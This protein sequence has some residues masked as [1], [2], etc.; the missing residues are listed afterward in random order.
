[1]KGKRRVRTSVIAH[2]VHRVAFRALTEAHPPPSNLYRI[3]YLPAI[4]VVGRQAALLSSTRLGGET[5]LIVQQNTTIQAQKNLIQVLLGDLDPW[6]APEYEEV[7]PY[8]IIMKSFT[9]KAFTVV[10]VLGTLVTLSAQAVPRHRSELAFVANQSSNNLYVYTIEKNGELLPV[11]G[12][13]ISAGGSPNSVAV[14]PSGRFAYVADV[15]P[16]GVTGFSTAENGGVTSVPGSPFAAP[17]GTAFVITD[18]GGRFLYALNCG[19]DCSGTGSGNIAAYTIDQGTG[20]LTPVAGSPF[21]AGQWPYSLAVDPT[22]QFAYVA[23]AGSGDVYAF[24]INSL[25]GVLT[26]I[27]SSLPAGTRPLSIVVDPWSQ[28]VYTANTGSSNVSAFSINFDGTLSSVVGSPFSAGAFTSA[29]AASPNG[30]FVVVSAG[31]GAFVYSIEAT[32]ALRSVTGSPFV[33]GTGPNGVSI[34]PTD[35]FVYLV[36]AGSDNVSGYIFNSS[37]GKLTPV[38]GSPFS[39]GAVAAGIATAPAPLHQ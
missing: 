8:E 29:I 34:D 14:V 4:P 25:S 31:P 21:T 7:R 1:L 26:Q 10:V 37:S 38:K 5:L 9:L 18:P 35:G 15:I 13:P 30:H 12:S 6:S 23:N 16:G 11:S 20:A 22:G 39:A 2:N 19:A 28:F 3:Q 17:T 36:N 32:G 24:A 33:A 27:G